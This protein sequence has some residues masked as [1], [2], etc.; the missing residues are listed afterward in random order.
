MSKGVT[1]DMQVRAQ[2]QLNKQER[3]VERI[4]AKVD[5]LD[6]ELR[7]YRIELSNEEGILDYYRAHPALQGNPDVDVVFPLPG[8]EEESIQDRVE[9]SK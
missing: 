2:E 9:L 8:L 3:L 6:R 7:E 5:A 4:K 1:R